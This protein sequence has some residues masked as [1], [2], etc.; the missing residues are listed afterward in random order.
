V[1]FETAFSS[2]SYLVLS[3]A[4]VKPFCVALTTNKENMNST[5]D[6]PGPERNMGGGPACRS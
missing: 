3:V 6:H 2:K 4:P 5:P 1:V